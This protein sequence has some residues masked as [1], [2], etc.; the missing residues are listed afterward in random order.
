MRIVLLSTLLANVFPKDFGVKTSD[1][2]WVT[3][4]E[5][6]TNCIARLDS[7]DGVCVERVMK[8]V[9]NAR[10]PD[11]VEAINGDAWLDSKYINRPVTRCMSKE[12]MDF[13]LT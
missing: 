6:D 10:M 3:C 9:G 2:Q 5:D 1:G 8:Q 4:S 11:Y 7:D 12:D 13:W